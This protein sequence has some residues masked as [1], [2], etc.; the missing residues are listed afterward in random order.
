MVAWISSPSS[1]PRPLFS[2][3]SRGIPASAAEISTLWAMLL[4][5]GGVTRPRRKDGPTNTP[6]T[7]LHLQCQGLKNC[8]HDLRILQPRIY[9]KIRR[10]FVQGAPPVVKIGSCF[11]SAAE[12]RPLL[13]RCTARQGRFQGNIKVD[14]QTAQI[15][16]QILSTLL[17]QRASPRGQN[18]GAWPAQLLSE[19]FPL[20][21][22]ETFLTSL[23]KD[24]R[25][26]HSGPRR[27]NLV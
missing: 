21:Q 6:C 1:R 26:A 3:S 25:Y 7:L 14:D 9:S 4:E 13:P 19:A 24:F 11:M 10:R 15:P 16:N 22:A 8:L 12:Q 18:H 20:Q 17:N 27:D 2:T 5:G 23:G